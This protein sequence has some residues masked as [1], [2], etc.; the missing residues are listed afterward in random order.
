[1]RYSILV[2]LIVILLGSAATGAVADPLKPPIYGVGLLGLGL[3]M[4][5]IA[6]K[7]KDPPLARY[8]ATNGRLEF[9]RYV[10]FWIA[11]SMLLSTAYGAY[12]FRQE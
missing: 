4:W 6:K 10:M 1:M 11:I 12:L 3:A 9:R 2:P 8:L 7:Q 5:P